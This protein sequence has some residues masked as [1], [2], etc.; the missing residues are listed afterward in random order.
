ML[1]NFLPKE[2]FKPGTVIIAGAGPGNPELITLRV[3]FAILHA[4]VI[5]YDG[6]VNKEI[7]KI[8]KTKELIFAGKAFKNKSC[9]QEEIIDWMVKNAKNKKRVMRLKGG[10][11][12]IFGRGAEEIEG[13]RL[14]KIP[15]KIFSGIT[16]SQEA[17]RLM[18]DNL[19]EQKSICYV[20]GHKAIKS[21]TPG[22]N[23]KRLA[24]FN[25]QIIVYM[26]LSQINLI[27]SKLIFY[28]KKKSTKVQI[29]SDI[30]LAQQKIIK[31][32]LEECSIVKDK[33]RLKPPA[34]ILIN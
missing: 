17:N 32:N 18:R 11:S 5:I 25:G 29:L 3:Y 23:Y 19:D 7:L 24:K 21:L 20:T 2:N 1:N 4:D 9:T 34:I 16:S 8:A 6:L 13:L 33:Y 15:F 30:S 26:G 22:I 27:A 10:D 14:N 12:S 31:T 28:G